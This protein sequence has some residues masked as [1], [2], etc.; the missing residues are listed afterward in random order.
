MKLPPGQKRVL[1]AFAALVREGLSPTA[2]DLTKALG[3]RPQSL[4]QHLQ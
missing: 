2:H 4:R 3:L 1:E